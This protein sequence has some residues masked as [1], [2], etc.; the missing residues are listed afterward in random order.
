MTRNTRPATRS[1][2]WLIPLA[3][4]AGFGLVAAAVVGVW[5]LSWAFDFDGSRRR[6]EAIEERQ[7]QEA[8]NF[9]I[10]DTFGAELQVLGEAEVKRQEAEKRQAGAAPDHA[11][12]EVGAPIQ[13]PGPPPGAPGFQ[14]GR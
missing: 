5:V 3:I 11:A 4:F 13:N 10:G 7:R 6:Q 9:R 12:P 14:P 1:P 8:E 2:N